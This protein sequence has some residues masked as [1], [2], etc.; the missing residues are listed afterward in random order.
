MTL[1]TER[2]NWGPYRVEKFSQLNMLFHY[3]SKVV[4][5]LWDAV[6][7]LDTTVSELPTTS[8]GDAGY[9]NHFLLMGG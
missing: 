9:K 4:S 1:E 7:E 3:L 5:T 6:E 8:S 2:L